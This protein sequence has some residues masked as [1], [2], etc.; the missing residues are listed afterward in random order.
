M[1][2]GVSDLPR[3]SHCTRNSDARVIPLARSPA[4]HSKPRD[5]DTQPRNGITQRGPSKAL[6]VFEVRRGA[7]QHPS[8]ARLP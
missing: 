4:R 5:Y 1:A 7:A 8:A 2:G 3:P 6:P